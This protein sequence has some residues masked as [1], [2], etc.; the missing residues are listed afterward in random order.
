MYLLIGNNS[1]KYLKEFLY[2]SSKPLIPTTDSHSPAD[3]DWN[4][5][6]SY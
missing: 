6:M 1:C 3:M 5:E 4:L 2:N